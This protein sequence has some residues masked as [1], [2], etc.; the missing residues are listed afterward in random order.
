MCKVVCLS[1]SFSKAFQQLRVNTLIKLYLS[2]SVIEWIGC[3]CLIVFDYLDRKKKRNQSCYRI[4]LRETFT[5]LQNVG[6]MSHIGVSES[7]EQKLFCSLDRIP[8]RKAAYT[9]K[10]EWPEKTW[11]ILIFAQILTCYSRR[12]FFIII[13]IKNKIKQ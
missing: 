9:Q 7:T 10:E 5:T 2:N 12:L 3:K 8:Q 13:I 4:S 6:S 11:M 1:V